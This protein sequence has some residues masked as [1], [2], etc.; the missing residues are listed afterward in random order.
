MT[1]TDTV[2]VGTLVALLAVLAALISVPAIQLAS[3]PSTA[4]ASPST[5]S[6]GFEVRPY[7]EGVVGA[8]SSVSPLTAK[9]Q[10]DRD[11]VALLFAGLVRNGPGGT[12]V[13]DL[14]ERWSVDASGKTWTVDLRADARWHDGTPVTPDDVIFTIET[15]QDPAY[16]GPSA[17]SWSEV[18][19]ATTGP[20][21]VRFTLKTPLGGFM[22]ALTQP[23]AP[24]HLLGEV[25]IASLADDPFGGRPV[26]S[27]PFALTD[28]TPT[29]ASLVPAEIVLETESPSPTAGSSP[30][31]LTTPAPTLRPSRPLPYLA[32][33]ELR[34]Y[35][36]V[37]ALV[38]D[39]RA[40]DLDGASGLAPADAIELG[41]MDGARLVRY[42]GST[43]T[44]VL[45]NLRPGHPE[46]S[47]AA[48]R[49]SLMAAL[50][51][52]RLIQESFAGVAAPATG[53]IPPVSPMFDPAADPAVAYSRGA[54]E[55]GLKA[56]NWT[57]DAKG[58]R[59]PSA[60]QPLSLEVLSPTK[61][62]NPGLYEAAEAVVRDWTAIGLTAKHVALPPAEFVGERLSTGT[63]QVA[64]ADLRIGLDP[65]LYP[66]LA[67]SQTLTGGSNV[68]GVQSAELDTLL[69]KARAPGSASA[70]LAAYSALQKALAAGRYLLPVA[71]AD[72]VVVLRDT[73]QGPAIRQVTDGSD[74]FWDVL[75]WRLAVGR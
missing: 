30:D 60:K 54:A 2:I 50:N 25:P 32:G 69:E 16:T 36:D 67:S 53:P 58:W 52:E 64:V 59:L 11:L 19:V 10:A 35:T 66:L 65:D 70:R 75:T 3:A 40:G 28:L 26:G 1:R 44:A 9:T 6:P 68:I 45:L 24:A 21:Q 38:R 12:L 73:V 39:F 49:T 74:R 37:D 33:I 17:T 41:S 56:A 18:T 62:S 20:R 5:A 22:Q 55:A 29:S 61:A 15:L 4:T 48:V 57:K 47:P 27:G 23:I 14:A 42:P 8:P 51:R 63:F 13:P 46:F 31:S 7:V 43:L 72:E 71:F 34:F